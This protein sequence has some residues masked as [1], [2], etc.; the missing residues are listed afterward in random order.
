MR[1]VLLTTGRVGA[2]HGLHSRRL[3]LGPTRPRV[4]AGHLP[5]RNSHSV[6]PSIVVPPVPKAAHRGRS[7]VGIREDAR[8]DTLPSW[9]HSTQKADETHT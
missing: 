3:P 9:R 5:L 4:A 7:L 1:Q 8:L 2:R 6:S